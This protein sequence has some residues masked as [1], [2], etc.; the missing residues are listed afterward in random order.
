MTIIWKP[1][2][3]YEGKYEVSSCGL[4]K[5]C[6]RKVLRTHRNGTIN[7]TP[8]HEKIMRPK[9]HKAGYNCVQ[10]WHD[11]VGRNFGVH[12]LVALAFIPGS[13]P[14]VRHLDGDPQN[15]DVSNLAWGGFK[16]NEADKRRHGRTPLGDKH[17]NSVL[18]SARVKEIRQA[19][20]LGAT[21]LQ[22]SREHGVARFAIY[23]VRKGLTWRHLS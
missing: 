9:K 4:V 15:N 13:G 16:E 6:E 1:V 17:C 21:D 7:E 22:L 10:L 20:A 5:S 14:L 3:G 23:S 8:Y 11:A 19:I 2:P 18:T 12:Q